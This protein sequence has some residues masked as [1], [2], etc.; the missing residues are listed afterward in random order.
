MKNSIETIWKEGF[1]H[2]KSLVAPRIND[3][4]NRKSMHLVDKMKRRFKANIVAMVSLAIVFPVIHYFLD[5]SW[6]GVAASLLLLLTAA[7][8]Q[9]QLQGI[10]RLD[11]GATSLVYLRS[12]DRWLADVLSRSG[13]IARFIYP[14]YFLIAISTVWSAWSKQEALILKMQQQFPNMTI[15]GGVPLS[16][17][18]IIGVATMLMGYFSTKIYKWD[19]RLMY[20]DVFRKLE[21]TIAEMEKLKQG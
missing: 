15:I 19:V 13:K 11:P 7:Y 18:I 6:Q 16:V 1:L 2:E 8:N 10:K 12:F 17:V 14:V 9:R 21:G 4:Y 20:G 5:A 3:L